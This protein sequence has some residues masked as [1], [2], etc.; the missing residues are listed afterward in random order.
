MSAYSSATIVTEGSIE[1]DQR[2]YLADALYAAYRGKV[3]DTKKQFG[4]TGDEAPAT[5]EEF[6]AR[7]KA[8]TFVVKEDYLEAYP[9]TSFITWRDPAVVVD[10]A[11]YKAA[12]VTLDAA[13]EALKLKIAII[14]V[15]DGLAA[16]EAYKAPATA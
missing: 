10:K 7:I 14:A 16:V 5:M 6:V 13:Y 9:S 3:S 15:T 1:K 11:G 4:L 2:R 12:R 8:G